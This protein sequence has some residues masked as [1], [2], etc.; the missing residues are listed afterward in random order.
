MG[1]CL[2]PSLLPARL[3][4]SIPLSLSLPPS[5]PPSLPL[6]PPSPHTSFSLS[7]S[8]STSIS[9]THAHT[10]G[11][12]SQRQTSARHSHSPYPPANPTPYSTPAT[13]IFSYAFPNPVPPLFAAAF[14]LPPAARRVDDQWMSAYLH[15]QV[16]CSRVCAHGDDLPNRWKGPK[17]CT[18][19][20]LFLTV[21]VDWL[22]NH[23]VRSAFRAAVTYAVAAL[24][25]ARARH[26][27]CA[28]RR[29]QTCRRAGSGGS[30]S[31]H[32]PS[33]VSR[34]YALPLVRTRAGTSAHACGRA[35]YRTTP[36]PLPRPRTLAAHNPPPP[37]PPP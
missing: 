31:A 34:T 27:P 37:P 21:R 6:L 26:G 36:H 13:T 20:V 29:A 24:G 25:E 5:L 12:S 22:I 7:I 35:L 17:L 16:C 15:R 8:I 32:A 4:P 1:V 23:S 30:S 2:S 11:L 3:P 10:L 9:R 18:G 33:P 14:P 28:R 19:Q